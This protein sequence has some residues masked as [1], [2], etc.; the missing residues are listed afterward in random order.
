MKSLIVC[1]ISKNTGK[2]YYF[3]KQVDAERFLDRSAGYI[4]R[5]IVQ[6]SPIKNQDG[7][8]FTSEIIGVKKQRGDTKP[9]KVQLCTTCARAY[10][11]CSWSI[12][13]KPVEG[14]TANKTYDVDGN[15]Y[16]YEV[17]GCPLYEKDADTYA[18]RKKQIER[19]RSELFG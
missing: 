12:S 13:F 17:K 9:Y 6:G 3:D 11:L 16:S 10:A 18:E 4:H 19:L 5:T 1:L 7:E 14:W 2:K 15:F 8:E